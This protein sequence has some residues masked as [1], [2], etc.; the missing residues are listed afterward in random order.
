[1][2][3]MNSKEL[4]AEFKT[5]MFGFWGNIGNAWNCLNVAQKIAVTPL[6]VIATPVFLVAVLVIA[7][8]LYVF[9]MR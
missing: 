3:S 2:M 9:I 5:P 1:M 4:N 8:G 7:L 6:V